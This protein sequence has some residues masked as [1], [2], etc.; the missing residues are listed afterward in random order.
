MRGRRRS[1]IGKSA[2]SRW[3][4]LRHGSVVDRLVRETPDI[5]VHVLPNDVAG[6]PTPSKKRAAVSPWGSPWG[7]LWSGLLVAAV[8]LVGASIYALGD[9]TNIG[10]LFLLP[11]MF[12]ATRYGLRTG[13]VTG[14]ASAL[15][16]NF[17]FIPPLYTFT[18]QDPQN[19][20]T[21]VVLILVAVVSS[22][23]AS[24]VQGQAEIARRSAAQNSA[25]AGFARNLTGITDRDELGRI[26]SV[27][28]ARLLD[29]EAIFVLPGADGPRV[30]AG[31]SS[32][33][34]LDMIDQAAAGWALDHNQV[35]GRGSGTLTASDW[36]FQ[37]LAASDRV[38]AVLG[39]ARPDGGEI[40]RSDQ[41]RLLISL[42]DQASL[43]L[44]RVEL[45]G[46]MAGVAQL[47][48]RDHLRAA[49]LSSVSHDLRT[50]L[51]A[52]IAT[53]SELKAKGRDQPEIATI[54]REALRLNRFVGNL[55]DMVRIEA[56]ALNL[57][58]DPVDLTDA[59]A[60]ASHD[61]RA[62]LASHP[63][64]LDVSPDLPLVRADAQLLHHCLI[65]LIDNAAKY[66]PDGA[67]DHD[68]GEPQARWHPAQGHRSGKRPPAWPGSEG[69][70]DLCARRRLGS[71]RRDRPRSGDR[72]RVCRSDG[73]QR[74][75]SQSRR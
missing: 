64:N 35:A 6:R 42:I 19:V 27:E 49:L 23:L 41:H 9:I 37:P 53:L 57:T 2:R 51:T 55:L 65:N 39:L 24:R 22:Q 40:I 33:V 69:V 15:A 12:A 62:A 4:E 26:L 72:P 58:L 29:V 52:I 74:D 60:S 28:A 18:I 25:L 8:T 46:E 48:E 5:A 7:Y 47:R 36:M 34:A 70:R 44:E 13:I 43:A 66:S 68:L 31:S 16:Y 20:L 67:A 10:M 11:V 3:F 54:E 59:V 61:L 71:H 38:R 1:S 32:G 73:P 56:G 21:V 45:E 75:R 63:L 50:P 17:F 14:V 30:T